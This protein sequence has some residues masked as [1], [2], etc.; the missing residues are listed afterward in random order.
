MTLPANLQKQFETALA[1]MQNQSE[2]DLGLDC[3]LA[4]YDSFDALPRLKGRIARTHLSIVVAKQV[5]PFWD[6]M[7]EEHGYL[8][9]R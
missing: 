8:T 5:L 3:R 9:M 1:V 6:S 4:V 7:P 2:F